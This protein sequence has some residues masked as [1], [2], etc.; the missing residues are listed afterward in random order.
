VLD[1]SALA[2]WRFK[3]GILIFVLAFS[4]WLFIP[5]AAALQ[6]S[7][8]HTAAGTGAI[9][10]VNKA[11]LLVCVAVLG[12]AGFQRLKAMVSAYVKGL[13]GRI[14]TFGHAVPSGPARDFITC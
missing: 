11:L 5:L 12:R 10:A 13:P 8:A 14:A 6:A 2:G 4:L 3:L 9:F 1:T 7:V